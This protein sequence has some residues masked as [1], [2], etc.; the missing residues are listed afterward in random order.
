[1]TDRPE[2]FDPD[3]WEEAV[4]QASNF[5]ALT[6]PLAALLVRTRMDERERIDARRNTFVRKGA[7]AQISSE[8]LKAAMDACTLNSGASYDNS[9]LDVATK[10]ILAEQSRIASRADEIARTAGEEGLS[11]F[12]QMIRDGSL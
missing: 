6:N 11:I 9:Y 1:M 8:V 2:G 3:E 10:A 7:S 4:K 12:A 5:K